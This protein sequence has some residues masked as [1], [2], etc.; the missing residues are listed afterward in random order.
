M[1]R[2]AF[3]KFGSG[4]WFSYI[5]LVGYY[6]NSL[7]YLIKINRIRIVVGTFAIVLVILFDFPYFFGTVFNWNLPFKTKLE[8]P[9]YV[10][11]TFNYLNKNMNS[12]SRILLLPEVDQKSK[13]ESFFW[14]Y[15]SITQL[16]EMGLNHSI[17]SND[18][19]PPL[20]V[21]EVS[22]AIKENNPT[23]FL[24]LSGMLGINKVLWQGDVLYS[25]KKTR[26]TDLIDQLVNLKSFN[27]IK[28][29]TKIGKW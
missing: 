1:F 29:D 22:Q 25:D 8:V 21:K 23:K 12:N 9:Q 7:L 15:S 6:L 18:G 27:F 4:L 3:Y 10:L 2:S 26:S 17:V 11:D 13:L 19:S 16:P 28:N 20:L 14:G 24:T 5:F